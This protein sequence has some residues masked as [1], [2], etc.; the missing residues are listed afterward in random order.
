MNREA[1][2]SLR[3][4]LFFTTE[5]VAGL[6]NLNLSSARVFCSRRVK[7]GDFIRIKKDFYILEER[8]P[9]LDRKDFYNISNH[10]QVPSY[11]SFTTALVYHEVT[12]QTLQ[13]WYENAA[14]KRTVQYTC[15][16]FHFSYFKLKK[17]LYFGFVK[18]GSFFMA[19]K[20]KAFIDVCHLSVYGGYAFDWAAFDPGKLNMG[21]IKTLLAPFPERTRNRVKKFLKGNI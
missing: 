14:Q 3:D 20:E 12:T 4:R 18:I 6:F 21:L 1:W 13:G 11:V 7:Q 16:G 5:D 8:L 19:L 10:L 9:Y 17:E 15:A 2:R